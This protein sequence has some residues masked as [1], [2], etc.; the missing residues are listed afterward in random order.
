MKRLIILTLFLL[1]IGFIL[2]GCDKSVDISDKNIDTKE[3]VA[4]D[5]SID[6][7]KIKK[8]V[9]EKEISDLDEYSFEVSIKGA[10]GFEM[11][12]KIYKKWH[13]SLTEIIKMLG[14]ESDDMPFSINK[15]LKV[16][17]KTYQQLE[18]WWETYWFII[19]GMN[20]EDD[21]FN[22]KEMSKIVDDMVVDKK[23]EKINGRKLTCYYLDDKEEWEEKTCLDWDI[24]AYG[25]Y[26]EDGVK[27]VIEIKDFD[28]SVK[29]SVF[30]APNAKDILSTQDMMKMFQ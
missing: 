17:G 5:E 28:D 30:A 2:T 8:D 6:A 12:S 25:E 9:E 20:P 1:S 14:E 19:P 24:F 11:V 21:M 23:T 15:M 13:N 7:N 18:K 27:D 26:F 16:D 29:D 3:D 10:D 4:F 22:L